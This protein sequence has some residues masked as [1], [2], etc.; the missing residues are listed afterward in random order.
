M[1]SSAH[2]QALL[3]AA[4]GTAVDLAKLCKGLVAAPWS[5]AG[6][7]DPQSVRAKQGARS[8]DSYRGA[9]RNAWRTSNRNCHHLKVA[10]KELGLQ[11]AALDRLRG[12]MAKL[13]EQTRQME[14]A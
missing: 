13:D 11:R 5:A 8:A 9:R 7:L 4:V 2:T 1:D 10:R 3:R 12:Q 6:P 14:A